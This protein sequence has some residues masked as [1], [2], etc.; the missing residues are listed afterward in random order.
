MTRDQ[1]SVHA[2]VIKAS[3]A[4]QPF[5]LDD[6][7][8]TDSFIFVFTWPIGELCFGCGG[9]VSSGNVMLWH[10]VQIDR[11][12]DRTECLSV[13]SSMA[14]RELLSPSFNPPVFPTGL[15]MLIWELPT[16]CRTVDCFSW[17][18]G[19]DSAPA[20]K[21]RFTVQQIWRALAKVKTMT[22]DGDDGDVQHMY[23]VGSLLVLF[24]S[25]PLLSLH[26]PSVHLAHSSARS[27]SSHSRPS[28]TWW[29]R[30][31]RKRKSEWVSEWL[32]NRM[33]PCNYHS[34]ATVPSVIFCLWV[35]LTKQPP[36]LFFKPLVF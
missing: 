5:P 14:L 33:F 3:W 23:R 32:P 24:S 15:H 4:I 35:M 12:R 28:L 27:Q 20:A 2:N 25:F 13:F 26:L 8:I 29:P 7:E 34:E 10:L 31:K 30:K 36:K 19:R 17:L 22:D 9:V 11:Q 1:T 16:S 6:C 18:V 21:A